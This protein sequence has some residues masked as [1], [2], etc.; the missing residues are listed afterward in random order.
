MDCQ[1][2]KEKISGVRGAVVCVTLIDRLQSDLMSP[3]D[4]ERYVARFLSV[5]KLFSSKFLFNYHLFV[6]GDW[7]NYIWTVC[8]CSIQ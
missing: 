4:V 6:E 8:V 2:L 5:N 1:S 7:F 3:A